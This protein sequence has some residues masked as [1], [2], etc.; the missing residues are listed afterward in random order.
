MLPFQ[1][2]TSS[3]IQAEAVDWEALSTPDFKIEIKGENIKFIIVLT[4]MFEESDS[5]YKQYFP[6]SMRTRAQAC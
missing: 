3:L 5:A 6:K 4:S 2:R 1:Y